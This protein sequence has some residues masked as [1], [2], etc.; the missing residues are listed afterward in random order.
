MLLNKEDSIL[1]IL[2]IQERITPETAE[3]RKVINGGVKLAVSAKKIG[4]PIIISEQAPTKLGETIVD[5]RQAFPK[6]KTSKAYEYIEKVHFS[7][8]K[9]NAF[10]NAL[11]KQNKKQIV[12]AGVE[13]HVCVLQTA[14]DLIDKGYEIFV[15]KNACSSRFDEDYQTAIERMYKAGVNIITIEMAIFEWLERCNTD[16][17]KQL[18]RSII[19]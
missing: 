4:I 17:F 5:I 18:S 7:C 9:E 6:N 1:V 3:P 8:A 15:V 10:I 12:I 2:D 13:T 19:K 14:M 11:K 16:E